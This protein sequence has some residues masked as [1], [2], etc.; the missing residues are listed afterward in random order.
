MTFPRRQLL[1]LLSYAFGSS[2]I[3]P[4]IE[5]PLAAQNPAAPATPA[6]PA[7]PAA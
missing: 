6:P 4:R 1:Q 7:T 5:L 3:L 2:V